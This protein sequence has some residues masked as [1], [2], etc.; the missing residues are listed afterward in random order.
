MGFN[1]SKFFGH[2]PNRLQ[3]ISAEMTSHREKMLGAAHGN[4]SDEDL[5]KIQ[6]RWDQYMHH[7]GCDVVTPKEKESS[8]KDPAPEDG[9]TGSELMQSRLSRCCMDQKDD[10][11]IGMH[12]EEP[13][14][15]RGSKESMHDDD[16]EKDQDQ[17]GMI[18]C[19]Q[20]CDIQEER[21]PSHPIINVS[22]PY[23]RSKSLFPL[24]LDIQDVVKS[25]AL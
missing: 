22:E 25:M 9:T 1:L 3:R 14:G 24:R 13:H 16:G 5:T 2:G 6:P 12:E 4:V 7:Y 18:G 17:D 10:D 21:F 8:T 19:L 20:P 15:D 11:M 23:H